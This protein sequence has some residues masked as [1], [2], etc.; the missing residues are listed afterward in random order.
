MQKIFQGRESYKQIV[1][2]LK[3]ISSKK[4][5]LVCGKNSF[6]ALNIQ[7]FIDAE[8]PDY[9]RFSGFLPNPKYEQVCR[10]VEV[11][12]SNN[13]DAIVAIGG[14]SAMDVAK[15]IKLFCKMNPNENYLK[16]EFADT[17]IPLI[18]V[19]TTAGT[20]SEST[21][22]AVIYYNDEKQSVTHNSIVPNYAV[23]DSSLLK[24]LPLYQK[25]CAMLDALC[26]GIESWWSVNSTDESKE[27]SKIAVE[28]IM[29]NWRQYIFEDDELA[30]EQIM[31]GS[32][33]TGR[34][35]NIT[36][37]TAPHAFSYKL[38]SLYGISHGHAVALCLF[39]IWQRMI[40]GYKEL[41]ER[42]GE[43]YLN[44]IF[45][46]ISRSLG[47][48][49]PMNAI[50]SCCNILKIL[51]IKSPIITQ[52]EIEILSSSVNTV[53]LSNNPVV[54]TNEDIKVVYQKIPYFLFKKESLMD[55][56]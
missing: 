15:C 43:E 52:E 11:F 7:S 49:S 37:T 53:R 13:C 8:C 44:M 16:Q 23:L 18:A 10:G 6:D 17:S 47:A 50:I 3:E 26:Q 38:T 55:Y 19:P 51:D 24:S 35:I 39:V 28:T 56:K 42:R 48:D 9:V 30:A 45:N 32:N 29:Q 33:Y 14:G 5:L 22:F 20:G 41:N 2:I 54:F 12:N 1:E 34:A 25:K 36:Q 46:D 21:R 27:Y 31:I 4:F 40:D